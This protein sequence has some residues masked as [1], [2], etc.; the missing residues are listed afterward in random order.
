VPVSGFKYG[1]KDGAPDGVTTLKLTTAAPGKV[2]V[3][4]KGGGLPPLGL[5]YASP[6]TV[7][8]RATNGECWETVYTAPV[9]SDPTQYKATQ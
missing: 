4:G 5:P 8:L 6:V 3:K 1:N 7:Q 9:L 2:V